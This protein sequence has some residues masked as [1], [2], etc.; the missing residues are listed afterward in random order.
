MRPR[1]LSTVVTARN[2]GSGDLAVQK[3]VTGTTQV[4]VKPI[5]KIGTQ[6]LMGWVCGDAMKFGRVVVEQIELFGQL[7][8]EQIPH[9]CPGVAL[10]EVERERSRGPGAKLRMYLAWPVRIARIGSYRSW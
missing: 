6:L 5:S 8:R 9:A 7:G 10:L 3:G 1:F 4:L 2:E